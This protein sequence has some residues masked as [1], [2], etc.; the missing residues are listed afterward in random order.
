MRFVH[1]RANHK[2]VAT[3]AH[4]EVKG[5]PGMFKVGVAVSPDRLAPGD[6]NEGFSPGSKT[7]GRHWALHK[8]KNSPVLW[9]R[10]QLYDFVRAARLKE[11]DGLYKALKKHA[12]NASTFFDARPAP[13][14]TFSAAVDW[15]SQDPSDITV[16]APVAKLNPGWKMAD[17]YDVT[18]GR[19]RGCRAHRPSYSNGTFLHCVD[20]ARNA[21]AFA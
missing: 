14:E 9:S 7:G 16:T 21:G 5:E 15:G 8:L 2:V 13:T 6:D 4:I 1:F 12:L 19:C 3:L 18:R 17:P 20:C 10:D 11:R